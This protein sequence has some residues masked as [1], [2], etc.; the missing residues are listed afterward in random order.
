MLAFAPQYAAG[1]MGGSQ[2]V[3]EG[4]PAI[5]SSIGWPLLAEPVPVDTVAPIDDDIEC[6]LNLDTHLVRN[7]EA[8]FLVRVRGD[9][10]QEIS[11]HDGDLLIM[12][13]AV[14]PLAGSVALVADE[15]GFILRR[16][17]RDADGKLTWGSTDGTGFDSTQQGQGAEILGVARW[18][19]HRLW[20]TRS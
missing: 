19:V 8:S 14:P 5:R 12:D 11:L 13:R 1:Q 16:L 7:P 17:H 9:G 6:W 2:Q 10:L 3:C 15:G 20:P 18:V 4:G